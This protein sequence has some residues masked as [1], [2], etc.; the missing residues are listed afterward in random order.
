MCPRT[1][2][3]MSFVF[4]SVSSACIF[5]GSGKPAP[6]VSRLTNIPTATPPASLP[7]PILLGQAQPSGSPS[8]GT[9][10][11]SN[12][13]VL[14]SGDTLFAVAT[15]L[16]VPAG[17]Q[18]QWVADV[19]RLNGIA[20]ATLLKTGVEL[21]LPKLQPTPRPSGTV[22]AT[23]SARSPTAGPATVPPGSQPTA[24]LTTPTPAVVASGNTYTVAAGDSPVQIAAK[25]GVPLAQQ[26][27]WA[28]Q[29]LVLNNT[30]STGLQVGQVLKLPPIPQ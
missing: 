4:L 25:L 11:P 24:P 10:G 9:G 1:L 17:Q 19:L 2:V 22:Q 13:Y 23:P 16:G 29:L 21:T 20:D 27:A 6:D 12:T 15:K 18:A 14:Q 8:A 3:L 5:G 26:D 7:T 30:T 28:N